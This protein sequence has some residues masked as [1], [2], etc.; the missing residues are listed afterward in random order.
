MTSVVGDTVRLPCNSSFSDVDWSH[1]DTPTSA[2]YYVYTNGVVYDIFRP[3]FTVPRPN[4]GEFDLEISRVQLGDAGLYVCVD[5]AGLG[6]PI[7]I[8][9]LSVVT[10]E[11]LVLLTFSENKIRFSHTFL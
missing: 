2:V 4:R 10:G 5:D 3:R 11:Q 8:Y 9:Q 6:E 1:K 7:Y